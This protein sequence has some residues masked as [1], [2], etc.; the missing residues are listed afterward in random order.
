MLIHHLTIF[1]SRY[2]QLM[3]IVC[4]IHGCTL[5]DLFVTTIEFLKLEKIEFGGIK[6]RMLSSEIVTLH[7][8][9]Q[10]LYKVFTEKSYDCLDSTEEVS[11]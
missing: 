6:G 9:F 10:S 7:E 1:V 4:L 8:E 5:Q 2:S 3:I 11:M